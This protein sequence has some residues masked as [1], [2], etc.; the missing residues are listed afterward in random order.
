MGLEAVKSEEDKKI[1][2]K[3]LTILPFEKDFYKTFNFEVDFVGHPLLDEIVKF[4]SKDL[5]D[6]KKI[7]NLSALPII[8][9]LPG[10]RKQ[11][12]ANVLSAMLTIIPEFSNYQ[13]VIAGM[14]SI[15]P[16]FYQKFIKFDNVKIIYNQTY[17][18]LAHS[19][20][21]VVTSGTATLETALFEV[22]ELVCYKGNY[23]SYLLANFY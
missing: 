10:S 23:F 19:H 3:M 4:N 5:T 8:A 18:L 20:S 6:F 17:N 14:S 16:D 7:N 1:V 22:P 15:P 12:I 9:L 11:E 21:A 2:D 13:F